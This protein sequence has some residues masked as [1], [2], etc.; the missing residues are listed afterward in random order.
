MNGSNHQGEAALLLSSEPN[1]D[2]ARALATLS[3]IERMAAERRS[4][5]EGML[6]EARDF[7]EQLSNERRALTA[8]ASAAEAARAAEAEAVAFVRTAREKREAILAL[9]A[10]DGRRREEL[11]RAEEAAKA[12]V[13]AAEERLDLARR[14]LAT[15]IDARTAQQLA[16]DDGSDLE[17]EA[18]AEI[19]AAAHLLE[20]RHLARTRADADV[21]EMRARMELLSGT[22]GLSPQA[23]QRVVERRVADM[24]RQDSKDGVR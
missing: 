7:Q 16:L 15:A 20:Q 3:E 4:V 23:V 5:A 1:A 12:A 18:Q 14:A 11:N 19:D 17:A 13:A 10:T 22:R 21:V 6:A 2:A 9:R 8:L 24:L